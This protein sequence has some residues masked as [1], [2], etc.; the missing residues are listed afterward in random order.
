LVVIAMTAYSPETVELLRSV[1]DHAWASMKPDEKAR[2]SKT[3]LAVRILEAAAAGERNPNRL[4]EQ[5][6]VPWRIEDMS[7]PIVSVARDTPSPVQSRSM[8]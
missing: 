4:L 7:V 5:A 1:L 2:S 3:L 6:L 8:P